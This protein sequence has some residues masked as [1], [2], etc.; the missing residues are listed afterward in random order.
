MEKREEEEQRH[1]LNHMKQ[2]LR[3]GFFQGNIVRRVCRRTEPRFFFKRLPLPVM[4]AKTT[5]KASRV[6]NGCQRVGPFLPKSR[7]CAHGAFPAA[8]SAKEAVA[9][10]AFPLGISNWSLLTQRWREVR[11]QRSQ[12]RLRLK[13]PLRKFPFH[14]GQTVGC[15]S[16]QKALE[17]RG[18]RSQWQRRLKKSLRK[19]VLSLGFKQSDGFWL[20]KPGSGSFLFFEGKILKRLFAHHNPRFDVEVMAFVDS[21]VE[22]AQH[23]SDLGLGEKMDSFVKNGIK[24]FADPAFAPD[25]T[26]PGPQSELFTKDLVVPIWGSDSSPLRSA[27]RRLFVE[28][29]TLA[30]ADLERPV[31]LGVEEANPRLPP[32]EREKRRSDLEKRL[33]GVF[34]VDGENDPSHKLLTSPTRCSRR[35]PLHTWHGAELPGVKQENHLESGLF[36]PCQGGRRDGGTECAHRHGLLLAVCVEASRDGY[37]HC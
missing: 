2:G 33:P 10:G 37:G 12:V 8:A 5:E 11:G 28:S 30:A 26:P 27:L 29:Y 3:L 4:G 25:Y 13:K 6:S 21:Q 16:S 19:V 17:D 22:F 18:H 32:V 1:E 35:T 24:C 36:G 23:V 7:R 14:W 20:K 31:D 34:F 15:A 9:C